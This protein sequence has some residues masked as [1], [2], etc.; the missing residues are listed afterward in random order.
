MGEK[1]IVDY[2]SPTDTGDE[3]EGLE[4]SK[5]FSITELFMQQCPVYIA[6]GMSYDEYWNGSSERTRAYREAHRIKT[7]QV[8][9]ELWLLGIYMTHALNASVGNMFSSKST[10]RIRYPDEPLPLTRKEQQE[11]QE[12]ARLAK[13]EAMKRSMSAFAQMY[14]HSECSGKEVVK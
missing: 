14:N 12:R 4:Q 13:I 11:Q 7:R 8:N 3:H 6:M 9:Q 10:N 2:F 1:R 5:P